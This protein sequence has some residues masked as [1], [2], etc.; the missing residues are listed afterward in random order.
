MDFIKALQKA[1]EEKR[2]TAK[3]EKFIKEMD[4]LGPK[5]WKR[6]YP[7]QFIHI[8]NNLKLNGVL[9]SGEVLGYKFNQ[10]RE[11]GCKRMRE[12]NYLFRINV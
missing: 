3:Q 2:L 5:G 6:K 9:P 4:E 10:S 1:L 7:R 12:Y 8:Q 11:T